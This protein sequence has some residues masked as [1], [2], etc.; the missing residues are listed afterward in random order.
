[1]TG[2]AFIR[3]EK[4]LISYRI[5]TYRRHICEDKTIF[6]VHTFFN[7][8]FFIRQHEVPPGKHALITVRQPKGNLVWIQTQTS[9]TKKNEKE[10]F[11][12]RISTWDECS[13]VQ[14]IY[15]RVFVRVFYYNFFFLESNFSSYYICCSLHFLYFFLF[16]FREIPTN[17]Q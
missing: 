13:N 6:H 3:L 10:K 9:S 2:G 14:V 16:F 5:S 12:Q 15:K 17:L 11:T 4:W 1:M 7:S 8:F